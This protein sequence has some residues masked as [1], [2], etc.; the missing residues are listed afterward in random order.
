ML[1][2]DWSLM[3]ASLPSSATALFTTL[4]PAWNTV[5][6]QEAA[7]EVVVGVQERAFA[8]HDLTPGRS[9]LWR[10]KPVLYCVGNK[11]RSVPATC[12]PCIRY[13]NHCSE[14]HK[15]FIIIRSMG[16]LPRG[17]SSWGRCWKW[18]QWKALRP[19]PYQTIGQILILCSQI[20]WISTVNK[21]LTRGPLVHC[22]I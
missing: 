8:T 19:P 14:K 20:I 13:Q 4:T 2:L 21:Q 3:H 12:E 1:F 5:L 11:S 16:S 22:E 18:S 6:G 7:G 9:A 17:Q 15:R 10:W